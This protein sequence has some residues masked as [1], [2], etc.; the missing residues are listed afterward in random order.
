MPRNPTALTVG[1]VLR[2][3]LP[4]GTRFENAKAAGTPSS[5]KISDWKRAPNFPPDLFA[6]SAYLLDHGGAYS[7]IMPDSAGALDDRCY[8]RISQ[9]EIELWIDAARAI[10]DAPTLPDTLPAAVDEL[11]KIIWE[12]AFTEKLPVY[13]NLASS[14]E[15]PAWW[16]AAYGLMVIADEACVDV[17]YDGHATDN[18]QAL[19]WIA[20][21]V[22][23]SSMAIALNNASR[24]GGVDDVRMEFKHVTISPLADQS[25]LCVQPKARTPRVGC[26]L[27][28]LTHNLALLPPAGVVTT[29]WQRPPATPSDSDANLNLLLVPLPYT[30]HPGWFDVGTDK[31]VGWFEL[32]PKWLREARKIRLFIDELVQ[33]AKRRVDGKIHG[34]IFPEYSLNWPL[35]KELR[36]MLAE[37]D[38]EFLIAGSCQNC[39][40]DQ[41]NLEVDNID[42]R[43]NFVLVS[44]LARS[45]DNSATSVTTSRPKHH[46]W[47]IYDG[48]PDAY[49]LRTVFPNGRIVYWE[50]I[51]LPRREIDLHVF[52][53]SSVFATMICEDLARSDPCHQVLR[54]LGPNIVFVLLMDGPQL[55]TRW[56][57]R[58][59][60]TL[61]DDPGSAV[62]TFTS[63]GLV[64]R[65]NA[66]AAFPASRAIAMWKD[67]TGR[68]REIVCP[69][70][71]QGVVI[72]LKSQ[73]AVDQT[74]DGRR[75]ADTCQ[76]LFDF[77]RPISIDRDQAALAE[78]VCWAGIGD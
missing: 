65:T 19:S 14:S 71:A 58:Y 28:S 44:Q 7:Y 50:K 3:V 27:R 53:N 16:R 24:P 4:E 20:K 61:A 9:E 38:V 1:N 54:S 6:I 47:G 32:R 39:S 15:P 35:F 41:E 10:R 22:K 63:M 37:H 64:D 49:G 75:N 74:L 2:H 73:E 17:G 70:T 21:F 31:G 11:W 60:S 36:D 76:W 66:T 23:A 52:R 57:A 72:S 59:A 43:G 26:T 30:I 29:H 48:Q 34:V 68:T 12:A 42:S 56:P 18:D 55:P 45:A 5:R 77:Q 33:S 51:G 46:R 13:V 67:D 25:V 40:R 69:S 78:D 8:V 62:L